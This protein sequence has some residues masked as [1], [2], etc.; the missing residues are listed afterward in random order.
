[1]T[2]KH[3]RSWVW[4]VTFGLLAALAVAAFALPLR[5][6]SE[7][8]QERVIDLGALG[9]VVF[10]LVFVVGVVALVPGSLL[11]I[12]AGAAYGAWG[13]PISLAAA[14]AGASLAFLIARHLARK[15]VESWM[16]GRRRVRAVEQAVNEEGWK[17]VL[18]LRLSPLVPFNLQNYLLGVTDIAFR[19]Y[20]TAT[21]VG[22][23]P[24]T[25]VNV[26]LG[27]LAHGGASD[28]GALEWSFFAFGL[29]ASVALAWIIARKAKRKLAEAG[30]GGED[31]A[32]T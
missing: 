19:H 17:V 4:M 24:G 18:L 21:S 32:P 22:I 5:E 14:I 15:P 11:S 8:L 16:R 2:T 23:V 25:L 13:V 10:M 30:L 7:A 12:T 20:L 31:R 6:W 1:M 28:R 9:A 27:T 26:Y 29:A 3:R